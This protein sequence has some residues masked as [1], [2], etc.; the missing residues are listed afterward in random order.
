M[1]YGTQQIAGPEQRI[2]SVA[3]GIKYLYGSVLLQPFI[4]NLLFIVFPLAI[5]K[6]PPPPPGK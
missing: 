2:V 3:Q 5:E 4:R 1:A 6:E